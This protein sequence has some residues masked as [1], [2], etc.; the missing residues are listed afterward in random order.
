MGS[1]KVYHET[2]SLHVMLNCRHSVKFSDIWKQNCSYF[3][4]KQAKLFNVLL[5]TSKSLQMPFLFPR[6]VGFGRGISYP[7]FGQNKGTMD[8][9]P[10]G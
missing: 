2:D 1:F 8:F 7:A 5:S 4:S 6:T 3:Y 10:F 9:H